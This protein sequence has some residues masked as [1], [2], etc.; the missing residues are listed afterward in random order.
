[1]NYD[2][3]DKLEIK[4]EMGYIQNYQREWKECVNKMN[5]RRIPKRVLRHQLRVNMRT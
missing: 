3:L 2:I 5:T 4:P 1:M